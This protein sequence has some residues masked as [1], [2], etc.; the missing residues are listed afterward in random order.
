VN[1]DHYGKS[2]STPAAVAG[3]PHLTVPCGF[4]AGLPVGLSFVGPAWSEARLLRF[5]FAFEQAT[6]ALQFPRLS[7]SLPKA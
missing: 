2:F 1:G 4:A 6:Q 5:G 7:P 3:Y